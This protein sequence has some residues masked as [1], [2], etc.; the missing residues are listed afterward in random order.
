MP[1]SRKCNA[2]KNGEIHREL[3]DPSKIVKGNNECG[4]PAKFQMGVDFL[5]EVHAKPF[6]N[7]PGLV[8]T[9]LSQ[10]V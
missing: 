6:Q 8:V 3:I 1:E 5:C 10:S 9:R 4:Q 2:T 7:T